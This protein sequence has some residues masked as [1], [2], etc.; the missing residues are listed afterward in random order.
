MCGDDDGKSQSVA[1]AHDTGE[2]AA[3]LPGNPDG[4]AL[5]SLGPKQIEE[6]GGAKD[7]SNV[8]AHENV[9]RGT[10]DKVVVAYFGRAVQAFNK[11]LLLDVV[12]VQNRLSARYGKLTPWR[13]M[14][15][16]PALPC[17]P[18]PSRHTK[19]W[20]IGRLPSSSAAGDRRD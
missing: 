2:D 7:G 14:T 20:H 16:Q 9:V 17:P 4:L 6:K 19:S 12:W 13:T 5:L 3:E 10:T 18:T 1:E 11:S 8:D 15:Y